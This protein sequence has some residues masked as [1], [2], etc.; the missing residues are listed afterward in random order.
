MDLVSPFP[1]DPSDG[2]AAADGG[3]R[4]APHSDQVDG[5]SVVPVPPRRIGQ[6]VV[7]VVVDDESDHTTYLRGYRTASRTLTDSAGR[8]WVVVASEGNWSHVDH[9][10][11]SMRDP[12]LTW[13]AELVWA[14]LSQL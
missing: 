5:V 1:A 8:R 10:E 7:L 13:P 11:S 14:D 9:G 3:P 12:F 6:A 2:S 4:W